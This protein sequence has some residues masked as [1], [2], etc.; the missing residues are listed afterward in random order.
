MPDAITISEGRPSMRHTLL[1]RAFRQLPFRQNFVRPAK[2]EL[3]PEFPCPNPECAMT[4]VL[5]ASQAGKKGRCRHCYSPIRYAAPSKGT[6]AVDLSRD[7][8]P[9]KHPEEYALCGHRATVL[10]YIPRS[11]IAAV[12]LLALVALGVI[13]LAMI[14]RGNAAVGAITAAHGPTPVE[15]LTSPALEAEELVSKFLTASDWT[16]SVCHVHAGLEVAGEVAA[17]TA[18]IP[19][20]EFHTTANL[21]QDGSSTVRVDFTNGSF[22]HF[23]VANIDGEDLIL[24]NTNHFGMPDESL[25][26]MA[27]LP[28]M[29]PK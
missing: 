12:P 5:P 22:T 7:L 2:Q 8:D 24:W 17:L 25:S 3:D 27:G 20:G 11:A 13:L 9:L 16:T 26:R 23:Q 18:R 29:E 19:E 28:E 14:P 21:N 15:V 1:K 4:L 10:D 6:P